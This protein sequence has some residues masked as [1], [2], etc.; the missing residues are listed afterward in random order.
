[1]QLLYRCSFR[2]LR[3]SGDLLTPRW[4]SRQLPNGARIGIVS[5]G[6]N[7]HAKAPRSWRQLQGSPACLANCVPAIRPLSKRLDRRHQFVPASGRLCAVADRQSVSTNGRLCHV[8]PELR[9][10][11]VFANVHVSDLSLRRVTWLL[12][13]RTECT[14]TLVPASRLRWKAYARLPPLTGLR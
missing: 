2:P 14:T 6:W 5:D 8:D 10:W 3:R 12:C 4:R 9:S 11:S 13:L 7:V 1:M